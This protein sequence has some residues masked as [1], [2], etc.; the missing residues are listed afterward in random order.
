MEGNV[1]AQGVEANV[2]RLANETSRLHQQLLSLLAQGFSKTP[3]VETQGAQ[4]EALPR[5]SRNVEGGPHCEPGPSGS[6][7]V[8]QGAEEAA[9]DDA[10]IRP[11]KLVQSTTGA[12]EPLES[13]AKVVAKL[14]HQQDEL[15]AAYAL[16]KGQK[17]SRDYK[18][19]RE[20]LLMERRN[21]LKKVAMKL[22]R[23]EEAMEDVL[24]SCSMYKRSKTGNDLLEEGAKGERC[25]GA[26]RGK[27]CAFVSPQP[28]STL[29]VVCL[30]ISP[31]ILVSS[32]M[33]APRQCFNLQVHTVLFFTNPPLSGLYFAD[34]QRQVTVG[35]I[36]SYAHK[37][38][39]SSFAPPIFIMNQELPPGFQPPAP[40][41]EHMRGSAL[42][43]FTD[44]ELGFRPVPSA[45]SLEPKA[46]GRAPVSEF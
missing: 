10:G 41:A 31:C 40:Q 11:E 24:D 25:D 39:Y 19:T 13:P 46:P 17:T 30:P 28:S 44:E 16:T 32:S 1:G 4:N 5:A 6:Q 34:S 37:I 20:E 9:T 15:I 36:V 21:V 45:T 7:K 12:P 23:A 14:L 38:S 26:T 3:S 43:Q 33:A 42:Y 27:C 29:R 22:H 35:D 18:M 8:T 2:R